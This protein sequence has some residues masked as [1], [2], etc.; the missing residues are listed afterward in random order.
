MLCTCTCMAQYYLESPNKDL[1]VTLH[2]NRGRRGASVFLVPQK[3]T[4]KVFSES[5]ILVD[6]EIGLTVKSKGRRYAFGKSEVKRINK[7]EKQIDHPDTKSDELSNLSGQYNSL[8]LAMENG[9]MLEVRAYNNGVAYRFNVTGYPEDYK[10]LEFCDVF[11]GESPVAILGTFEGDYTSPWH[12]L[13]VELP[14]KSDMRA[15]AKRTTKSPTYLLGTR[16]IPWRDALSSI[17]VGSA[18]NWHVGNTW[19]DFADYHTF[20]VD[21]TYKHLYGGLSFLPCEEIQYIGWDRDF[22]PFE[23]MIKGIDAW[24]VGARVGY[25]LPVQN[26]YEVWS[27]IPYVATTLIHLH[28]HGQIR[29]GYKALSHH[30]HW[31]VGP[32]VKV[33][34]AERAGFT[35]GAGYEYQFFTDKKAPTGMHAVS[36]SLGKTF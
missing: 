29:Y 2:S 23:G 26:C 25:C 22:W 7:S 13:K 24:N 36:I 15:K 20:H 11:P 6:K 4:M 32:G 35:I 28:Q 14:D 21:F 17:S 19:G 9:I 3:M 34:V 1:R 31:T 12:T 18:F 27:F 30:A 16:F 8:T 5:E 10:I 33:Q